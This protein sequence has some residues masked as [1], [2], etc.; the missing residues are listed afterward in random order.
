LRHFEVTNLFLRNSREII[1]DNIKPMMVPSVLQRLDVSYT[2]AATDELLHLLR[3]Q[4]VAL[5][6]LIAAIVPRQLV[7]A[8]IW[9]TE[10]KGI[11]TS[12]LQSYLLWKDNKRLEILE[13]GGHQNVNNDIFKTAMSCMGALRYFGCLF[14]NCTDVKFLNDFASYRHGL[15]NPVTPETEPPLCFSCA[16]RK[17][18]PAQAASS[19]DLAPLTIKMSGLLLDTSDITNIDPTLSIEW[20]NSGPTAQQFYRIGTNINVPAYKEPPLMDSP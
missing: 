7:E 17:A 15:A 5:R 18:S 10:W 3:T 13:V 9:S 8:P 14:T 11:H 2:N 4:K 19:L 12:N 16:T 1:A 6:V 20:D